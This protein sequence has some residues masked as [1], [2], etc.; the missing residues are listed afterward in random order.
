MHD[1]LGLRRHAGQSSVRID[2]NARRREVG[3][4]IWNLVAILAQITG[5]AGVKEVLVHDDL[6]R[7]E[8]LGN[9]VVQVEFARK[10]APLL[11]NKAV[12]ASK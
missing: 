1:P 2:A 10:P 3:S 9:E 6:R 12:D 11:A 5:T 7:F 8:L 4:R